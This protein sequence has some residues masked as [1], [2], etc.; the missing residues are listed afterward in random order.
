MGCSA[1]ADSTAVLAECGIADPVQSVLNAPM[2]T[3]PR[4]Q[5]RGI[6]LV[7]RSAGHGV[8]DFHGRFAAALR[9]AFQATGL[10]QARPVEDARQ[11]RAGLQMAGDDTAVFLS[12]RPRFGELCLPLLFAVGGKSP[13]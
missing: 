11:S 6:G 1:G 9:S 13:A 12:M 5:L 2:P 7:P 3:P 4:Q 8:L 10:R